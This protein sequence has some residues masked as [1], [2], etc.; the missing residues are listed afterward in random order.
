M[1]LDTPGTESHPPR[2]RPFL[3]VRSAAG[4]VERC[5]LGSH[6]L[7]GRGTECDLALSDPRVSRRH[8]VITVLASR[9][10]IRDCPSQ[11]GTFVNGVRRDQAT[12]R[13]G[14]V[15]RIGSTELTL[16]M[17]SI[18]LPIRTESLSD[19]DAEGVSFTI[20]VSD[21]L[22]AHLGSPSAEDYLGRGGLT[23]IATPN[24]ESLDEEDE[25]AAFRKQTR[26][27]FL[28]FEISRVLQQRW[29]GG[30]VVQQVAKKL[31]EQLRCSRMVI[32]RVVGPIGAPGEVSFTTLHA[33]DSRAASTTDMSLTSRTFARLAVSGRCGVVT[34]DP[35][36]DTRLGSPD[37][38]LFTA[39]RAL[40]C[41][42]MIVDN[43]VI[44]VIEVSSERPWHQ[45]SRADLD[46]VAV[47][48]AQVG[49]AI[50]NQDLVEQRINTIR[51]LRNTEAQLRRAKRATEEMQ[52]RLIREEQI[53]TVGR[54]ASKMLHELR[55]HLNII[56]AVNHLTERYPTDPEVAEIVADVVDASE[57]MRDL[58]EEMSAY[59]TGSDHTLQAPV[60]TN[61]HDTCVRAVRYLAYD[62]DV[63]R[64]NVQLNLVHE[65]EPEAFCHR[66]RIRQVIINLVRNAA[67]AIE[68]RKGRVRIRVYKQG[69]D[70]CIDVADNGTGMG[71]DVGTRVFERFYSTKDSSGMGLGLEICLAIIR[72]H[73][74]H[75][76]FCTWPGH[77]TTFTLRLPLADSEGDTSDTNS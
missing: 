48:A 15:V 12:L 16:H 33:E 52:E 58:V 62:P 47:A 39:V 45:F 49:T 77:G 55:N 36:E 17:P 53:G 68:H 44:G 59:A 26:Y 72:S 31:L 32:S 65:D 28:M 8:A 1:S 24:D 5:E 29:E 10:E 70:A 60:R 42:P 14:D 38:V 57:T 19:Q 76:S 25:L 40:M 27:L 18:R 69:A 11:N 21:T 22:Y 74:G 54:F 20:P 3:E 73:G 63:A 23:S 9:V 2:S 37:S 43:D 46:L 61:L 30:A 51:D 34:N 7:V 66:R 71:L 6:L 67:Q 50:R 4:N 56:H 13:N 35:R 64:N 75:L 41:V